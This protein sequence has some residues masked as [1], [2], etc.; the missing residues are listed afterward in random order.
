MAFVSGINIISFIMI[1]FS[2]VF[3]IVYSGGLK[4]MID[5]GLSN[6]FFGALTFF[7]LSLFFL[8]L[9]DKLYGYIYFSLCLFFFSL[10][11]FGICMQAYIN[12]L[13]RLDILVSMPALGLRIERVWT[14]EELARELA[15]LFEMHRPR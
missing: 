13:D 4:I 11:T 2:Y 3:L 7:L 6:N 15:Q 5:E 1:T 10:F 8:L 9:Y 14:Y 12:S